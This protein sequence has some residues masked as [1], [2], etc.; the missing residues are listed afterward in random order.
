MNASSGENLSDAVMANVNVT[1]TR[2]EPRG[3]LDGVAET[4]RL[5][6]TN[7]TRIWG[8]SDP[9]QLDH[10]AKK[11]G[12]QRG[13]LTPQMLPSLLLTAAPTATRAAQGAARLNAAK[14][15]TAKDID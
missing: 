7:V 13:S 4:A 6:R 5:L 15:R 3:A 12:W 11:G 9:L 1:R 14:S 10:G 8:V 2:V